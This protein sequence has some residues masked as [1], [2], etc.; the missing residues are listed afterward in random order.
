MPGDGQTSFFNRDGLLERIRDRD[1][2]SV[3]LDYTIDPT[4]HGPDA[5]TLT[6]IR[7]ATDGSSGGGSTYRR[8][9][10][11]AHGTV[12]GYGRVT[13]TERLG[14][15]AAPI[16]GRSAQFF[17]ST[18]TS[19]ASPPGNT[20]PIG[21]LV[22]VSPGRNPGTSCSGTRPTGCVEF[23]Y[24]GTSNHSI[25]E[26]RDPRWDHTAGL[27][28]RLSVA[29]SAGNPVSISDRSAAGQP[30][31]LSVSSFDRG[32]SGWYRVAV[33][34]DADMRAA[35]MAAQLQLNPDGTTMIEYQ[36]KSCS[37]T[38]GTSVLP[39]APSSADRMLVNEFNGLSRVSQT[40]Q[41]RTPNANPTVTRQGTYAAARVDN[42][43]DPLTANQVAWT[44]TADQHFASLRDS[45][46]GNP[47]LYRTT[48]AYNEWGRPTSTTTPR[49]NMRP[50]Y[51]PTVLSTT[52]TAAD[53]KGYWRLGE[54]AG[55]TAT[56]LA[57]SPNHGTVA[58]GT[59]LNQVGAL[60]GD[61]NRAHGSATSTSGTSASCIGT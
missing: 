35:N 49:L 10:E 14:T 38:C 43:A 22:Y 16:T 52:Q 3:T 61:T 56:D 55:T 44:Q 26:V 20:H 41:Y 25:D 46:G 18:T 4:A 47:D 42:I 34:Q 39:A 23:D 40:T 13:F 2:S 17:V 12:T 30:Q 7:A 37:G 53:L 9:L 27:D 6:A 21:A 29:Y 8:Y 33:W 57:P 54:T 32:S 15:T 1:G 19:S 45:G 24:D 58:S 60:V 5:Y 48:Y 51:A 59:T 36:P 50:A 11:V 28:L 31:L